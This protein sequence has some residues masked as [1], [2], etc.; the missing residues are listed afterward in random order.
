MFGMMDCDVYVQ[1]RASGYCN[2]GED[3]IR[4]ASIFPLHFF[5]SYSRTVAEDRGL[6]GFDAINFWN[7]ASS[8][9]YSMP[10]A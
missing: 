5:A 7:L 6:K 10:Q 8:R 2:A 1:S 9:P 3:V 4:H